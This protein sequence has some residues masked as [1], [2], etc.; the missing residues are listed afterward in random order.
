MPLVDRSDS[1]LLVIDVQEG[2]YPDSRTDVDRAAFERF[3]DRVAWVVGVAARLR[4]PI[5]VTEEDRAKN[6]ETSGRVAANVPPSAG[7]FEKAVFAAPD[8]PE[9]SVAIDAVG[10]KTAVIVGLETDVCVSHSALRLKEQS[11][12]VVAVGDALFSPGDAH[13]NG[14]RRLREAGV[15]LVSAKELFYDWV[16]TLAG[17]RQFRDSNPDLVDPPGF[18]L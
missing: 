17:V 5:I 1:M 16:P 7:V 10:A 12:R 8:N 18:S 15:E 6:G 11:K 4:V 3:L 14:L 2:F 13:S 9:I